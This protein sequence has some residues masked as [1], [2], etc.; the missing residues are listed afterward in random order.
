MERSTDHSTRPGLL[1]RRAA[2]CTLLMGLGPGLAACG[3]QA[4]PPQPQAASPGPTQAGPASESAP[5]E[6]EPDDGVLS[7]GD[8][9]PPLSAD[10]WFQGQAR[11]AVRS[12]RVTVVDFW[13][14]W[15]GPCIQAMPHLSELAETHGDDGLDVVAVSIDSGPDPAGLVERFLSTRSD[16]TRFEVMLADA[17]MRQRWFE[18]AGMT[19]I[20][21]TMVVDQSGVLAWIGHPLEGDGRGGLML[22]R[23][24]L[25]LLD[26]SYDPSEAVNRE[27]ARAADAELAVMNAAW[28]SN[29]L[30]AALGS[31]DRLLAIDAAEYSDLALRKAEI[32]LY[33]LRRSEEAVEFIRQETGTR[34][35]SDSLMRQSFAALLSGTAD[36]GEDGRALAVELAA[37]VAAESDGQDRAALLVLAEAHFAAGNTEEAIATMRA[38]MRIVG[39]DDPN[40]EIYGMVV[41]RYETAT[42][43]ADDD[44]TPP[45]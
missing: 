40:A 27:R 38:L 15:C 3:E 12:G 28:Q 39:P 16:I 19:S 35:A 18:A 5:P 41:A 32:L 42:A 26:G 4:A 31:I 9:A 20:P 22:D 6:P 43:E 45:W 25:G 34:Y 37:G 36:P 11:D 30:D 1:L 33:E 13:A 17:P 23:V 44:E 29:D 10:Q 2:A 14:T 24:A 7:V 8:V 21:T